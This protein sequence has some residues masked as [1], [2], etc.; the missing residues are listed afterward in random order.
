[1]DTYVSVKLLDRGI[2]RS[3]SLMRT[4]RWSKKGEKPRTFTTENDNYL[5]DKDIYD[6]AGLIELP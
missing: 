5:I 3:G 6:R 4:K 1:M 2:A